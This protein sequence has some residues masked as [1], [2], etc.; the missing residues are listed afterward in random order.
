MLR[1]AGVPQV[2]ARGGSVTYSVGAGL[3]LEGL[4]RWLEQAPAAGVRR[5]GLAQRAPTSSE[6]GRAY[7]IAIDALADLESFPRTL[8]VGQWQPLRARLLTPARSATVV[9]TE[10]NSAPY[11]LPATLRDGVVSAQF[12]ARRPGVFGVQVLPELADGPRPVIEFQCFVDVPA[13]S[14]FEEETA[15]QAPH[16]AIAPDSDAESAL[17]TRIN[18]DR[19]AAGLAALR[20]SP[21]LQRLAQAHAERMAEAHTLAHDVGQG[22]PTKRVLDA[23]VDATW[24]G[25]NVAFARDVRHAADTLWQSPS[26]RKNQLEPRFTDVGIGVQWDADAQSLWVCQLF[27]G[28]GGPQRETY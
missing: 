3:P 28:G 4:Q 10:P 1:A 18:H 12:V 5:C 26:H 17:L 25:E 23:R 24:V 22:P 13:P 9:V 20:P 2:W 14:A 21:A 27:A 8:R 7:L 11:T 16:V 19:A 6:T 15:A